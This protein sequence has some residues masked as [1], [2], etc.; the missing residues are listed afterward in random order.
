[1][2]KIAMLLGCML[3]LTVL[4]LTL[5]ACNKCTHVW[6]SEPTK[7]TPPTC[8]ENGVYYYTCTACGEEAAVAPSAE[9][10]IMM[11]TG[12]TKG[13][14]TVTTPLT[15]TEDG[16]L[17]YKCVHCDYVFETKTLT[18]TGHVSD[19]GHVTRAADCTTDGVMTY[20][21]TECDAVLKTETL[22]AL[23]HAYD[24]LVFEHDETKHWQTCSRCKTKLNDGTCTY[25]TTAYD[26][27]E[28]TSACKVCFREKD[29]PRAV[30]NMSEGVITSE[31]TCYC[32]GYK[33]YTCADCGYSERE[34]L[35]MVDHDF[36][37]VHL[38][39]NATS[40][41]VACRYCKM[42]KAGTTGAHTFGSPVVNQPSSSSCKPGTSVR[43]CSGCGYEEITEVA[44]SKPH[45]ISTTMNEDSLTRTCASCNLT[46]TSILFTHGDGTSTNGLSGNAATSAPWGS[47]AT[48]GPALKDGYYW[49]E[50]ND[51]NSDG[52]QAEFYYTTALIN[53]NEQLPDNW[54]GGTFSIRIKQG[55]AYMNDWS[56]KLANTG[57]SWSDKS[58]GVDILTAV[59]VGNKKYI[60]AASGINIADITIG[61]DWV[62]IDMDFT[63]DRAT[64]R[65][66]VVYYVNGEYVSKG[67]ISNTLKN[68]IF[69]GIYFTSAQG[70]NGNKYNKK[71][72]AVQPSIA[73]DDIILAI[74]GEE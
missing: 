24:P 25:V 63:F 26:K 27:D 14:T 47:G 7:T 1:M 50:K 73:F 5:S 42:L 6:S 46:W 9:D 8:T 31:P 15:C 70:A 61:T 16:V 74:R 2:K 28:H 62:Q 18:A 11:A 41:W 29:D 51:T 57:G 3:L 55:N 68:N 65:I 56:I 71:D 54:V 38:A 22:D 40:H 34:P 52:A 43:T 17:S 4:C 30:H 64:D 13:G 48:I 12:H 67:I 21:C 37:E 72:P 20:S 23:G 44:S 59:T 39:T 33:V 36:D 60:R 45:A 10:A 66:Y 69:N 35:P 58:K 49:Y 19:G 32:N 53:S